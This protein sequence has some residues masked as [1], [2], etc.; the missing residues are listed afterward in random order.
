M[1]TLTSTRLTLAGAALAIL[2]IAVVLRLTETN[3]AGAQ[4]Q[5]LTAV[6]ADTDPGTDPDGAVWAGIPDADVPLTAQQIAYPN[7]GGTIPQINVRA[8]H[9][10]NRLY[11]RLAWEDDL[12]DESSFGADVFSD[13]VATMF[14][15]QSAAAAP[16]ITMGQADAGVN[17]WYWRADSEAGVPAADVEHEGLAVDGYP[18]E[19]DPDFDTAAAA[20]N[21]LASGAA[22]QDLIAEGFGSLTPASDP[23]AI[24]EGNYADGEWRV[25]LVRDFASSS[26]ELAVFEL[27]TTT[28]MAFA[29]WDGDNGDR[30][31]LKSIS[32][33]VRLDVAGEGGESGETDDGAPDAEDGAEDEDDQADDGPAAIGDSD[34]DGR[35]TTWL[36]LF[37]VLTP[38]GLVVAMALLYQAF[39]KNAGDA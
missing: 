28:D 37:A 5:V 6:A 9:F 14:P 18:L 3:L 31:G 12:P 39:G 21:V 8:A 20:G 11:L 36:I 13:A 17:I 22:V 26:P 24:G 1:P 35:D 15:A 16:A 34:D 2:A 30:N 7:G 38:L 32:Q 25:V 19:D 10:D 29:V 23:A 4:T 33:F 27:G